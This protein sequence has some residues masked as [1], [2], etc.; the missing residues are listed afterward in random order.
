MPQTVSEIGQHYES[1]LRLQFL[2]GESAEVTLIS[3]ALP[4]EYDQTPESWG[5]VYDLISSH[6]PRSA[7]KGSACW[8]QLNEIKSFAVLGKA[9]A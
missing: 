7:P 6:R 5:V 3:V 9:T 8:S 1:Q 4:N 2:D